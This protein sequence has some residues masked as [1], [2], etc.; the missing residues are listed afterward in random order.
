MSAKD[1]KT[2][3]EKTKDDKKL[4]VGDVVKPLFRPS[5][6]HQT[7]TH[8]FAGINERMTKFILKAIDDGKP[9]VVIYSGKRKVKDGDVNVVRFDTDFRHLWV[10]TDFEKTGVADK[11]DRRDTKLNTLSEEQH[12]HVARPE[13][14]EDLTKAVMI[15]IEKT[16]KDFAGI[17]NSEICE[18]CAM[19]MAITK[20]RELSGHLPNIDIQQLLME[21]LARRRTSDGDSEGDGEFTYTANPDKSKTDHYIG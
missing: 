13:V 21:A 10:S 18:A 8:E 11:K 7:K 12:V 3:D 6:L 19:V 5:G 15:S 2:K 17:S 16:M 20:A 14:V 4:V 1:E 9:L